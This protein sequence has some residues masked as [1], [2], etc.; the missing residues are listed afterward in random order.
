MNY[1]KSSHEKR[2]KS[3]DTAHANRL[4][5]IDL[6]WKRALFFWGF[7]ATTFVG[8]A[9]M[10]TVDTSIAIMV[11][12]FGFL[13]SF[14]WTLG[15]RGSKY[16]QEYWEQKVE[17]VELQV[18]GE[19]FIDHS[20]RSEKSWFGARK[21]SVSKLAIAI[22]DYLVFVWLCLTISEINTLFKIVFVDKRLSVSTFLVVTIGYLILIFT[23]ARSYRS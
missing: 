4:F 14:A 18:V 3:F 7:V 5:E 22:S 6:F 9:A 23:K 10:R 11:G 21:F 15:N 13:A 8:F 12:C 19:L 16:W 1:R 20:P 17:D 2:E